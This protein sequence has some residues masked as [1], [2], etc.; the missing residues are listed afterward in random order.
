MLDFIMSLEGLTS[1]I[2]FVSTSWG[3]YQKFQ[4][5][6]ARK[7]ALEI[8]REG[9]VRRDQLL[10]VGE[11]EKQALSDEIQELGE[12]HHKDLASALEQFEHQHTLLRE[13]SA[14]LRGKLGKL[15]DMIMSGEDIVIIPTGFAVSIKGISGEVSM[16][17]DT[18][19]K[20][21]EATTRC[22]YEKSGGMFSKGLK[23]VVIDP[24]ID[25]DDDPN[26]I[27]PSKPWV[28]E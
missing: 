8:Q 12:R 20:V 27:Q 16:L 10:H 17:I 28:R 15:M 23:R 6:K 19:N 11:M 14:Y 25:P 1:G 7:E 18:L 5:R 22:R 4:T 3:F 13:K 26:M 21:V 9:S 24:E 2:A